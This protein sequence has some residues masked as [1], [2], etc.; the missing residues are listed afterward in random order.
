MAHRNIENNSVDI[1]IVQLPFWGVGCPSLGPA[2]LKSYLRENNIICKVLDIN[3]EAYN[4]RGRK[5]Q[6]AW[7]MK[8]ILS[9]TDSREKVLEYY[10]HYRSLFLYFMNE[11][12]KMSPRIVGA[13]CY[14]SSIELTKIFLQ[15]FNSYFPEFKIILGGPQ[16]AGFMN[17]QKDLLATNYID[18]VCLDEGEN[19][20]VQYYHS[21][22]NNSTNSI[23]GI[24]YKVD[25]EII[26]SS[27]VRYIANLDNLPFPDFNDFDLSRYNNDKETVPSYFSRGCVN[28]CIYCTERNFMG[29]F[30][31]RT[32]KRLYEEVCHIKRTYPD[33]DYVR[34][35]DS[36]A[37]ANIRELETFCDLL[38]E[39]GIKVGWDLEN[40]V[41]R[42]EMRK[43]LYKKLKKAGCTLIGYGL[44]T[45]VNRLL[46]EIGK[47]TARNVDIAS[48]IKE[49][50]KSGIYISVN[51]M[52]GLPGETEDDFQHLLDFI[53]ENKRFINMINP[54]L[55]FCAFYPGSSGFS[56]PD[57]CNIENL[58]LGPLFWNTKDG[59]NTYPMRMER[60]ERLMKLVRELKLD[61]FMQTD[62]V[63]HKH[64]LLF[65]Y[66]VRKN[67]IEKAKEH[68]KQIDVDDRTVEIKQM[69]DN[70][71]DNKNAE[72][73]Q[74]DFDI[75]DV[76]NK[77][78]DF[79]LALSTSSMKEI[80]TNLQYADYTEIDAWQSVTNPWKKKVRK[81][82]QRIIG[83]DKIK[84]EQKNFLTLSKIMDTRIEKLS[85]LK[86]GL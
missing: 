60:Y 38:I 25:D 17:N 63:P 37:N 3:V 80:I 13:T 70:L 74:D 41:I 78:G 20:I 15:E 24:I 48:V 51:I 40:A 83:Y 26:E 61:N 58:S 59:Q 28:K 34:L 10:K 79:N 7:D 73:A 67:D 53:K 27:P 14:H 65:E 44:E 43:P 30:R 8:N 84:K 42:K 2:L 47:N 21:I 49:A 71:Q 81:I 57:Q 45:P 32:G 18:A 85:E 19:A 11:I 64:Q 4:L 16:V 62:E 75:F 72:K 9:G 33:V 54:S 82:A 46:V 68:Y 50:K 6:T 22:K 29:K 1:V 12:V 56:N 55:L 5:Y 39:N 52:I 66:Y 76:V 36:I 31:F 23:S 35:T 77:N 69:Y 86:V